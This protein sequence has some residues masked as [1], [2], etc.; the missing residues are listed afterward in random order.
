V[1]FLISATAVGMVWCKRRNESHSHIHPLTL[2]AVTLFTLMAS[3]VITPL[4]AC[5]NE[6]LKTTILAIEQL[7]T[8]EASSLALAYGRAVL[9][10]GLAAQLSNARI[11]EG[12]I[13]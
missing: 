7:R 9:C 13:Y 2:L 10:C 8:A 5:V 6:R 3:A 1:K 11:P 4:A 12:A